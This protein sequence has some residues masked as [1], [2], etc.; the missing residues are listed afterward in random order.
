L[1]SGDNLN[2][3]W[4][5]DHPEESRTPS[6]IIIVQ[7]LFGLEAKIQNMRMA[8]VKNIVIVIPNRRGDMLLV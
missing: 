3:F 8:E 7:T 1:E 5:M 4:L 2:V 6:A